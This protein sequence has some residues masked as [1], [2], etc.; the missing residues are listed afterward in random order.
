MATGQERKNPETIRVT[1]FEEFS[2]T[3]SPLALFY[4]VAISFEPGGPKSIHVSSLKITPEAFSI[5]S[6][7]RGWG[8][9]HPHLPYP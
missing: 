2:Q 9:G 4:V 8:V 7:V 5:K 6:F 1:G 3:D